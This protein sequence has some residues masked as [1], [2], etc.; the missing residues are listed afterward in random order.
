MRPKTNIKPD[1][2][3]DPAATSL[4]VPKGE[5]Q[6]GPNIAIDWRWLGGYAVGTRRAFPVNARKAFA[7]VVHAAARAGSGRNPVTSAQMSAAS[8][9]SRSRRNVHDCPVIGQ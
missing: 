4:M 3:S 7:V 8:S 5:Q 2:L 1:R 9:A 6:R